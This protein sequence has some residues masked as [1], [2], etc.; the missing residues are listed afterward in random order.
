MTLN[1]IFVLALLL[2]QPRHGNLSRI[3]LALDLDDGVKACH[4][5][6]QKLWLCFVSRNV[7]NTPLWY[8]W[9][10]DITHEILSIFFSFLSLHTVRLVQTGKIESTLSGAILQNI[11]YLSINKLCYYHKYFSQYLIL[12]LLPFWTRRTVPFSL[13]TSLTSFSFRSYPCSFLFT[14][15]PWTSICCILRTF[16]CPFH[17]DLPCSSS[18]WM[19][20]HATLPHLRSYQHVSSMYYYPPCHFRVLLAYSWTS[21]VLQIILFLG[22]PIRVETLWS[23]KRFMTSIRSSLEVFDRHFPRFSAWK[24]GISSFW[25]FASAFDPW[26]GAWLK[27]LTRTAWQWP[28]TTIKTII[29][30]SIFSEERFL[31]S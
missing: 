21:L 26:S 4:K 2:L 3:F 14:V 8:S 28:P 18:W 12:R 27:R 6:R 11:R 13:P 16:F 7:D 10:S 5:T 22:I 17:L 31:F 23:E 24:K 20:T 30:D 15:S 19:R 25:D 9:G 1:E 29:L